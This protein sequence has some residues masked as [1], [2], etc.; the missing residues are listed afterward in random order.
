MYLDIIIFAAIAG[1]L[2]Y[3]LNAVLGTRN[4][5]EVPRQN[6]FISG[7]KIISLP[8]QSA[9]L[10]SALSPEDI[11][12]LV[13][14]ETNK[15]GRIE[16]GLDEIAAADTQFN[17][18]EFVAGAKQAF[19]MIV[20]AH[21]KG[22]RNTL[23]PLLSPNLYAGFDAVIKER[24]AEG[25]TSETTIHRIKGVKIVE[26]HLG[27]AMAYITLDYDVEQTTVTRDKTGAV[28]D[29]NPDHIHNVED[30]WTFMRDTRSSDPNWTLIETRAAEK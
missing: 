26:A 3:R 1:L 25:Q 21:A 27:G 28:I 19:E 30:I 7:E 4:D 20:T 17:A 16:T 10:K 22:D 12:K 23:K 24:E 2:L 6:P 15:D 8:Q 18:A 5:N 11:K 9:T 14:P 13:D 29:G